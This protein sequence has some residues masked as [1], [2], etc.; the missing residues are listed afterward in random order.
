MT[1]LI[2]LLGGLPASVVHSQ[3]RPS[4]RVTHPVRTR[5]VTRPQ[6]TPLP[7]GTDPT[8]VSTAEE[9]QGAAE[10]QVSAQAAKRAAR[11]AANTDQESAR[12]LDQLSQEFTRLNQKFDVLEKQRQGDLLQERLT[13]AEQRAEGLRAQLSQTM[14]K[15]ADLQARLEQLDYDLR[16]E[17]IQLRAATVPSLNGDAVRTQ[18]TQQLENE[19]KRVRAQLDVIEATRTHLETAIVGADAETERLR[20]RLNE[21]LDNNNNNAGT[22][23]AAVTPSPTPS[24]SPPPPGR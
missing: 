12:K 2:L 24:S 17:S 6:P 15:Q 16:P 18:I 11:Q 3:R 4:R 8:L 13:R 19:K 23:G 1:A 7:A 9:Q 22:S 21:L 14:E 5:P 10:A 20:T